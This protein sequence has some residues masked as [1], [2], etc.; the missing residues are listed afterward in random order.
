MLIASD[1]AIGAGLSSSAALEVACGCALADLAG[2]TLDLTTLAQLGRREG[3]LSI[4]MTPRS[5]RLLK[6]AS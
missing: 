6:A 1:V 2:I 3:V 4:A 5:T